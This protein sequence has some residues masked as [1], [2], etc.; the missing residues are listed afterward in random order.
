MQSASGPGH[1]AHLGFSAR[2]SLNPIL[3]AYIYP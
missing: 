1:D 2:S 3:T